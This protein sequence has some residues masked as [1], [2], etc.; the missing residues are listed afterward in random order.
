M[1]VQCE[2][3]TFRGDAVLAEPEVLLYSTTTELHLG[4]PPPRASRILERDYVDHHIFQVL[5]T[6]RRRLRLL[7]VMRTWVYVRSGEPGC[8]FAPKRMYCDKLTIF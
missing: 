8:P 7:L 3:L 4:G 2:G 1:R 6:F 5:K